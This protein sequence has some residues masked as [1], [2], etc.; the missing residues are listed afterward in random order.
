[1]LTIRKLRQVDL[2]NLGNWG[3]HSDPRLTHYDFRYFTTEDFN[4][5][6]RSKQRPPFR[7]IY[8]LVDR[9]Q[10]VGYVTMKHINW[11]FRRAEFGLVI[12]PEHLNEGYGTEGLLRFMDYYFMRLNMRELRLKVAD[13]NDRA[14]KV[15]DKLGFVKIRTELY[16][17]E[18]QTRSFELLLE[19]K[20]FVMKGRQIMTL[21]H[22]MRMTRADYNKMLGIKIH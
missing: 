3:L 5:W 10:V 8:A 12:D 21:T 4:Y 14:K 19:T 9:G 7:W 11:L 13:F 17:F 2:L 16:P 18:D 1:M 22:T 6:Y 20:D 15:Y